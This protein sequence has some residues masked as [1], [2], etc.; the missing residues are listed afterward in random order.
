[1]HNDTDL[2]PIYS[3]RIAFT[4]GD[5]V[6]LTVEDPHYVTAR[7]RIAGENFDVDL[8]ADAADADGYLLINGNSPDAL[9]NLPP[10]RARRLGHAMIGAA[11]AARLAVPDGPHDAPP[12]SQRIALDDGHADVDTPGEH[13]ELTVTLGDRACLGIALSPREAQQVGQALTAAAHRTVQQP[14]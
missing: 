12:T 9:W 2:A 10:D 4:D 1:M 8:R 13:V 14:A 6:T 5:H 7:G 3:E 11:R